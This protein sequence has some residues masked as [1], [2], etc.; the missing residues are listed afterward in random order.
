[1]GREGRKETAEF[2]FP[3]LIAKLPLATTATESADLELAYTAT[4]GVAT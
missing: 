3:A 1:V 2:T 4:A